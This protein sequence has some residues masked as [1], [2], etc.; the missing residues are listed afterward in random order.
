MNALTVDI[1]KGLWLTSNRHIT[2]RPYRSR[3]VRDLHVLAKHASAGMEPVT[4][5]VDALWT[6][7]YPKGVTTTKGEASNAQPTTK[8]LLD[9]LC[10]HVLPDDGPPHVR[11]ER[12]ERGP[13]LDIPSIHRV[14]LELVL[15]A[16]SLGAA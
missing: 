1:P 10:P 9:G 15:V 4:G 12:F 5:R 11:S 16:E 2:N 13:N 7:Q 6:V 3:I 14:T 8:A